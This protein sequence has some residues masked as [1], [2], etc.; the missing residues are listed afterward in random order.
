V[1]H[2]KELPWQ[3]IV[4]LGLAASMGIIACGQIA[5]MVV[6]AVT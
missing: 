4:L 3:A 5:I 6:W 2:I 1:K